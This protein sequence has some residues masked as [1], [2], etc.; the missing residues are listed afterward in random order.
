M[1]DFSEAAE[2]GKY[3]AETF[4]PLSKLPVCLQW[5]RKSAER[6]FQRQ[7]SI[8]MK[9]FSELQRSIKQNEAPECFVK[10]F[11]ESSYEKN[12][13]SDLQ[14]S[15]VAGSM[16]STDIILKEKTNLVP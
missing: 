10:S 8:W 2:P 4:P 5:W 6:S 15:F 7:A 11:I 13:I 9:Y 3:L 16:F 14:A 12:D 1:Q